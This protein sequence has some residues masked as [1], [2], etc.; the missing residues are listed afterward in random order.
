MMATDL[1]D[2]FGK[3][4]EIEINENAAIVVEQIKDELASLSRARFAPIFRSR[5]TRP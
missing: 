3:I 5:R 4:A 1:D 2:V